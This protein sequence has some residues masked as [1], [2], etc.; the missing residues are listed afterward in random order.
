MM[1]TEVSEEAQAEELGTV[2][3]EPVPSVPASTPGVY[4]PDAD[5]VASYIRHIRTMLTE[6]EIAAGLVP[7][8]PV[9]RVHGRHSELKEAI[10]AIL[11]AKGPL[12][13]PEIEAEL[14][15]RQITPQGRQSVAMCLSRNFNRIPGYPV[16]KWGL[17]G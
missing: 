5:A 12:M 17:P 11:T 13:R 7:E 4:L 16:S 2:A 8:V 1:D 14:E 6:L 10:S 3:V 15:R 9:I